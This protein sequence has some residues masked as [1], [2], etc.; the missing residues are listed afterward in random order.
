MP[1]IDLILLA[2]RLNFRN[3]FM[4]AKSAKDPIPLSNLT[5]MWL[6]ARVHQ[7]MLLQMGQ[8]CET[9]NILATFL[10]QLHASPYPLLH[11]LHLYGRSPVWVLR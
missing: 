9:A 6:L 2:H 4:D 7:I 5:P 10:A 1:T 11:F 8:L 3:P